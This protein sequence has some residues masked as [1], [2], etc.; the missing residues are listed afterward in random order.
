MIN[1]RNLSAKAD[2]AQMALSLDGATFAGNFGQL[3]VTDERVLGM[4]TRGSVGKDRL[5]V[6]KRSVSAFTAGRGNCWLQQSSLL[7]RMPRAALSDELQ[8]PGGRQV[9]LVD[10]HVEW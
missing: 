8:D 2:Q 1:S 6:D 7:S 10:P 5:D 3:V 9:L 4:V